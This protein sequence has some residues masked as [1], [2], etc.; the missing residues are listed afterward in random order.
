M[1]GS[2]GTP[3][4]IQEVV[5][6]TGIEMTGVLNAAGVVIG[7]LKVVSLTGI[8]ATDALGSLGS[9]PDM[10]RGLTG[11][12]STMSLGSLAAIDDMQVGL[13]GLEMTGALGSAGMSPLHYKDV[14]ITGYTSY[15]DIEHTA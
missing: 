8:G 15:T 1:P 11:Y 9:I 4:V 2:V 5:G 12:S 13:S 7:E 14:D 3:P 10:K 6:L